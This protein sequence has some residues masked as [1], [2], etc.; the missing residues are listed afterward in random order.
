M[1]RTRFGFPELQSPN[2][3]PVERI[4]TSAFNN[5]D[6]AQMSRVIVEP[7]LEDTGAGKMPP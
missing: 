4:M 5:M 6:F 2:R 7:Q 1:N 3:M